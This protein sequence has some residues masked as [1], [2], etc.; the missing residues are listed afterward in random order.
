MKRT[1]AF[2][3]EKK[4]LTKEH[5]PIYPF[6]RRFQYTK[7]LLEI[8]S[9]NPFRVGYFF[10]FS[11]ILPLVRSLSLSLTL[12][13]CL[14]SFLVLYV[15]MLLVLNRWCGLDYTLREHPTSTYNIQ[16][17]SERFWCLCLCILYA[18]YIYNLLEARKHKNRGRKVSEKNCV[19]FSTTKKKWNRN[20]FSILYAMR[21]MILALLRKVKV[22]FVLV[23]CTK[24]WI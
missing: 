10:F 4:Q 14:S 7:I 3:V 16:W 12:V 2:S 8:S 20:S 1:D 17:T 11:L 21:W 22:T 6:D 24:R 13:L 15:M 18:V 19:L 23:M 9:L 5:K